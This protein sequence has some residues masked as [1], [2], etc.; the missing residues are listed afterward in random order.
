MGSRYFITGVQLGMLQ[1]CLDNDD[2]K[3]I[4]KILKEIKEKQ[5]LGN[6]EIMD[7]VDELFK[8]RW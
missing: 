3:I 2:R 1:A 7:S 6:T 4:R 8:R 5:F